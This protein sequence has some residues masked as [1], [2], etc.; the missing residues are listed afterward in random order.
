MVISPSNLDWRALN[1]SLEEDTSQ[2]LLTVNTDIP[3]KYGVS[4]L[5]KNLSISCG[6]FFIQSNW[7]L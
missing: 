5:F 2:A 4:K 3:Q 7:D 6:D 1:L